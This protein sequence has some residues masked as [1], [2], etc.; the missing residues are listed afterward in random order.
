MVILPPLLRELDDEPRPGINSL[1]IAAPPAPPIDRTSLSA[2]SSPELSPIRQPFS[3]VSA[4]GSA[5]R[6]RSFITPT[7]SPF[8]MW[9][10][11]P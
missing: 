5:P 1:L 6:Y 9:S 10:G 3:R 2:K 11:R 7:R 8:S 4:N